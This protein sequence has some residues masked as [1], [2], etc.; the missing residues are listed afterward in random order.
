MNSTRI[1]FL[2]LGIMGGG[3]ARRLLG[4]GFALTVYNRDRAKAAPLVEA[5]ARLADTPRAAVAEAE[6]VF[7]MVADDAASRA[8]WLGEAGAL[9]G[10]ARGAVL[11]EC[12]TLTVAWVRELAAA[13]AAQGG[14]FV[15]APVAGSK[16]AAAGGELKFLAGGSAEALARIRPAL[17]A[18]GKHV[19]HLGPPGSGAMMKLINN[20]LSG[21]HV[22][23]FAEA[24]AWIERSG[25]DRAQAIA[26]LTGG[27]VGSPV[28]KAVAGRMEAADYTPH[29]F[30][31]LMTKDLTYAIEESSRSGVDLAL[32]AAALGRF[33][34]A[35]VAGHGALDMA[36]VVRPLQRAE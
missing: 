8:M 34:A 33:R 12:S 7:S 19:I 36:A 20:F 35:V 25:L 18:M 4:A 3:M 15:D 30:L 29:F 1:A 16:D 5:G 26:M 10:V 6:L 32:A 23:A 31:R 13:V 2:G 22:A 21:V 28:T 9:A 14:A 27:A 24:L 17:D 11:V